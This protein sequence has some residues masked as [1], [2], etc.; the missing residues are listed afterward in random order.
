MWRSFLLALISSS[1][2]FNAALA[3]YAQRPDQSWS[4]TNCAS[5]LVMEQRGI[6][7]ALAYDRDVEQDGFVALLR[8]DPD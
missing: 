4:L 6:T 3:R 7:E 8:G 1:D 5:F 2:L